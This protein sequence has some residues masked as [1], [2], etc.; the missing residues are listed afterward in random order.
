MD[1]GEQVDRQ[2]VA[3]AAL[4]AEGDPGGVLGRSRRLT[5]A[6]AEVFGRQAAVE[7]QQAVGQ[8]AGEA[9]GRRV[10][11]TLGGGVLRAEVAEGDAEREGEV[12]GGRFGVELPGVGGDRDVW[13]AVDGELDPG[14]GVAP[15]EGTGTEDFDRWYAVRLVRTEGTLDLSD[16]G[17]GVINFEQRQPEDVTDLEADP[18]VEGG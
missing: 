7:E 16:D 6:V 17:V 12:V 5:Q 14:L 15:R 18:G 8:R 3:Q 10:E 4:R 13:R 11:D 2:G 9:G 1:L